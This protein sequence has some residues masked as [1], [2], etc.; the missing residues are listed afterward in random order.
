MRLR[1]ASHAI[2]A[3]IGSKPLPEQPR[4]PSRNT[5]RSA[6]CPLCWKSL[7]DQCATHPSLRSP[8]P[9]PYPPDHGKI[10]FYRPELL[11]LETSD[12]GCD[13][14]GQKMAVVK[15]ALSKWHQYRIPA[16]GPKAHCLTHL[17][18]VMRPEPG[19]PSIVFLMCWHTVDGKQNLGNHIYDGHSNTT[20]TTTTGTSAP[21]QS[22]PAPA[23][24]SPSH[25]QP[26]HCD[27]TGV[28]WRYNYR[29]EHRYHLLA[30]ESCI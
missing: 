18:S 22:L 29:H 28:L 12:R 8:S 25:C 1:R 16:Q 6:T 20:T 14:T 11:D 2:E 30:F 4:S 7:T 17:I 5:L 9:T 21:A 26:Q 24:A 13:R 23:T 15:T 10:T 27:Y 19:P 3:S